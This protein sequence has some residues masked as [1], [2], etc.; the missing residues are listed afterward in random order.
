[1]ASLEWIKITCDLGEKVQ[2]RRLARLLRLKVDD[3]IG[4]LFRFWVW[5]EHQSDGGRLNGLV[6]TDV[7]AVIGKRGFA[8]ALLDVGWLVADEA[9][10]L[11][12]PDFSRHMGAASREREAE[13][14]RKRRQRAGQNPDNRND[15]DRDTTGTE[16]GQTPDSSGTSPGQLAGQNRDSG[17]TEPGP[18]KEKEKE[19]EEEKTPDPPAARRPPTGEHPE[20]VAYFL[21]RWRE[22][23]R[24]DYPFG[25]KDGAHVRDLLKKAGG[26]DKL[27]PIIDRFLADDHPF[28]AADSRHDLGALLRGYKR[29]LVDAPLPP[30][31]RPAAKSKADRDQEQL[32]REFEAA[33]AHLFPGGPE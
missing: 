20:T 12:V 5:V 21:A 26:A 8:G 27:R 28:H 32:E 4:K 29:W 33:H 18:K 13:S 3:V 16:P 6:L 2:T 25:S 7:D 30:S 9:G 24:A 15:R 17:G 23:Y 10:N 11:A 22:K 14:E 31:A 1:M 19:K